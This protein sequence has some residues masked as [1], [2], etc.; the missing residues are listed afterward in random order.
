MTKV[1][2]Y[3]TAPALTRTQEIEGGV[4]QSEGSKG[5]IRGAV[6]CWL[7]TATGWVNADFAIRMGISRPAVLFYLKT[8][9]DTSNAPP[10]R[11]Q[12]LAISS[13]PMLPK[14]C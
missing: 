3:S 8:N 13:E 10:E 9:L 4:W 12:Q 7:S 6:C 1:V 2:I 5:W 14:F 11:L